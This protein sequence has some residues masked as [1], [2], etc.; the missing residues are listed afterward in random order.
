MNSHIPPVRPGDA[1]RADQQNRIIRRANRTVE[2]SG[3]LGSLS[4]AAGTEIMALPRTPLKYVELG[5]HVQ[6]LADDKQGHVLRWDGAA[7]VDTHSSSQFEDDTIDG[8]AGAYQQGVLLQGERRICVFD[9]DSRLWLPLEKPGPLYGRAAQ[10]ID[11]G[12]VGNVEVFHWDGD[13][14]VTTTLEVAA[15]NWSST[16]I[17]KTVPV[18]LDFHPQSR[19]WLIGFARPATRIRGSALFDVNGDPNF[20]IDT[21]WPLDGYFDSAFVQLLVQ[22]VHA[23]AVDQGE[24]VRAELNQFN[25]LWEVYQVTHA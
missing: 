23:L 18:V 21:L 20:T 8:I 6:G 19:R 16:T 10:Q 3:A 13:S 25:G 2:G 15:L 1:I 14:E 11:H 4:T 24:S 7:F 22:N 17:W 5:E 12:A 9:F